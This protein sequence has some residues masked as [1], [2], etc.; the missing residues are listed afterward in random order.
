M[1]E[2]IIIGLISLVIPFLVQGQTYIQYFDGADTSAFNSLLI[3]IDTSSS[4]IWQIGQPQK[5]IFDTAATFP[6][7]IVTDTSNYYPTN[8]TSSFSFGVDPQWFGWGI[9]ALQW[10]QKLDMDIDYD[11]GIIEFSSDTGNTWQNV[12]NNPYVY[13]FYG[14]DTANQDTLISGDY[15]F[16]GTDSTWKDIWL[17]F[18][19]S[20]LSFS[21]SL[22]FRY[23]LKSD[24][25]NNNKEGWII[26]NLI[27]HI[28]IIHTVNE[29]KQEKYMTAV[30][31][32]T[33]GRI[34][35][36]TKKLDE[37]H[38]IQKIELINIEGKLVQKWGI[39]P[40]KF[41]VDI[42][43]HPNGIYFLNVKT[44]KNS[45]TFKIVLEQ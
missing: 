37:F 25:I 14:F 10:K 7:S 32:P 18:D 15:A 41:Y 19:L 1:K 26:D 29:I 9:L 8:N 20:W 40:T 24:A 5:I 21:D 33:T 42:S 11:G 36:S 34:D 38:I 6:N 16:S 3:N 12:F 22:M 2:K 44:N 27:S 35:I 28:T 30:P 23:T 43:N 31:N 45:E 13:N 39:S 4:N 17:C